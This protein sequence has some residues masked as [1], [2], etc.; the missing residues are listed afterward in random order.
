MQ[1][2]TRFWKGTVL[3]VLEPSL[4]TEARSTFYILAAWFGLLLI[5]FSVGAMMI[6]TTNLRTTQKGPIRTDTPQSLQRL[7]ETGQKMRSV[8][9]WLAGKVL[10]VG[11]STHHFSLQNHSSHKGTAV[12]FLPLLCVFCH[13]SLQLRMPCLVRVP[14]SFTNKCSAQEWQLHLFA[15]LELLE[16]TYYNLK[17]CKG[18]HQPAGVRGDFYLRHSP[19]FNSIVFVLYP[20]NRGCH[21]FHL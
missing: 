15:T 8:L 9:I 14:R 13:D 19:S 18:V 16:D 7:Q 20:F 1:V 10:L 2:F 11:I 6:L 12:S 21:F 3:W 4:P 5:F 17:N